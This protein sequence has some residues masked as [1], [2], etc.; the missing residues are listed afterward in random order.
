MDNDERDFLHELTKK[1]EAVIDEHIADECIE[2]GL[3]NFDLKCHMINWGDNT[4]KETA[5]LMNEGSKVEELRKNEC[6]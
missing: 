3:Y 4:F 2:R 1:I 6:R 5:V